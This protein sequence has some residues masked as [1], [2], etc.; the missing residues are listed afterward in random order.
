MS[1]SIIMTNGK[2]DRDIKS[3]L[4]E[5]E[6]YHQQGL[7]RQSLEI[8]MWVLK[9][10]ESHERLSQNTELMEGLKNKIKTVKNVLAEV[11]ESPDTPEL[12]EDVQSLISQ[13]FSSSRK[14]CTLFP[15]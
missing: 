4:K 12:S 5:A 9:F 7:F 6:I 2:K 15:C 11:D 8:Y 3:L 13:L 10:M 1:Y 14:T